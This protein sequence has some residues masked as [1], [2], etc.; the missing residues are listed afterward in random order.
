[1]EYSKLN[2]SRYELQ[3]RLSSDPALSKISIMG[4]DPGAVGGTDLYK[5]MPW[6]MRTILSYVIVP[7]QWVLV[8]FFL[9]GQLRTASKVGKDLMFASF[10]EKKM[11]KYPG[12]VYIDGTRVS[13]TSPE[14]KD[15]V[16]QRALWDGSLRL[17]KIKE[18]DTSLKNWK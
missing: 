12:A 3:R 18:G 16:K 9:N 1:M 11:G 13:M 7:F 2:I 17:A 14:S 15:E 6:L 10:D 8:Y 4:M 5:P